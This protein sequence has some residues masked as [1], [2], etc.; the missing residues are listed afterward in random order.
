MSQGILLGPFCQLVVKEFDFYS[1]PREGGI[2]Q[3]YPEEHLSFV[4]QFLAILYLITRS[5]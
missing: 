4:F 3:K 5:L 2:L 1:Q